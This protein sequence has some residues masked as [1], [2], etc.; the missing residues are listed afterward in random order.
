MDRV[1]TILEVSKKQDYIFSSKKLRDNVSGS[2]EIGYVTGSA[3]FQACA[4]D[5]Y[6]EEKNL[7][8]AGGGHTVLQFEN[9]EQA[10]RFTRRVTEEA[11]RRFQGMEIF[12]KSIS[13]EEHKTPGENLNTL[14]AALEI[15]KARRKA[16]FRFTSFGVERQ[17]ERERSQFN[18]LIQP[19]E[20]WAFPTEFH[21]IVTAGEEDN[22]IAIVHIDG[23]AMGDRV[24]KLYERCRGSWP[25]CCQSLKRFSEGIQNDFEEAFRRTV[26]QLIAASPALCPPV[27]PIRPVI[28]AG[29]DVC[30]VVTGSLGLETARMYLEN[31]EKM[32][33]QEDGRPYA[34]CAGVAIVHEKYPF[35]RAYDLAEELCSNAKRYGAKLDKSGRISALDWHI[36]F[37][38]LKDGLADLREEYQTEDGNR[39]ELR[40]VA[41]IV[42]KETN[43]VLPA[44]RTY[45]FF[46]ILCRA[47]QG[48]YGTIARSK[49]KDL[50]AALKQ[51][52]VESAFFLRDQKICDLL[53]HALDA[54]VPTR[55][56]RWALYREMMTG[57]TLEKTPFTMT[58]EG[59][60][61]CQFFDAIEMIDHYKTVEE[62]TPCTNE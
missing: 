33:N 39:L 18:D 17:R 9:M 5:L 22:F 50:R 35:H 60:W 23:N 51:G 29:D 59:V 16:S 10:V 11:M 25:Q 31:L 26:E 38:E 28:L 30:F 47:L 13:Y 1:L 57:K 24:A 6:V 8:Y 41:V 52:I 58:E 3:F 4:G 27:L 32:H 44:Q 40:P 49:I 43:A 62:G 48:E 12:A 42:P 34:A 21:Q 20:P 61:R 56:E 54:A 14:T 37:G 55:E 2:A 15:K 7:V 53:Y 45:L 36:E 46:K 19:P